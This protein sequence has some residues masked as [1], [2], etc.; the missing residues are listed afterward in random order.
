MN[1]ARRYRRHVPLSIINQS[2]KSWEGF[3]GI[4]FANK[5]PQLNRMYHQSQNVLFMSMRPSSSF[6]THRCTLALN[7]S[8]RR[9]STSSD[10]EEDKALQESFGTLARFRFYVSLLF[11][12]HQSDVNAIMRFVSDG[13]SASVM[14]AIPLQCH[15][16]NPLLKKY[17]FDVVDFH[18]GAKVSVY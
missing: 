18:Q 15:L 11:N 6:R 1:I 17:G 10:T 3:S 5:L 14:D 13:I 16:Q 8:I 4:S 12:L 9:L 7:G 2:C